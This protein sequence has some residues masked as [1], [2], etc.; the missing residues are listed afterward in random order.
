MSDGF[1][2]Y[3]FLVNHSAAMYTPVDAKATVEAK[4]TGE[5]VRQLDCRAAR[6]NLAAALANYTKVDI[7]GQI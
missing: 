5:D 4:S 7:K 2:R 6:P 3:D 1:C